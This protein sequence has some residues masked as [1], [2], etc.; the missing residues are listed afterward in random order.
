MKNA[1]SAYNA[2]CAMYG[3]HRKIIQ[4]AL[5]IAHCLTALLLLS[6][7][8]RNDLPYPRLQQNITAIAAEGELSPAVIDTANLTVTL[9]LSEQADIRKVRFTEFAYTPGAECDDD[10][11][12]GTYDM[13]LPIQVTLSRYQSYQW[14]IQA[15]QTIERYF[16]LSG[17]IGQS[18]IDVPG[19]RVVVYMPESVPLNRVQL[20]S[21]KLGPESITTIS[22]EL[23]EGQYLDLSNPMTVKVS[24]YGRTETWTIFAIHTDAIVTTTQV[25]AWSMVIYAYGSAPEDAHNGFQYRLATARDWTNVPEAWVTRNGGAFSCRIPGLL[26]MTEYV[27]RATSDDNLGNEVTVTTQSTLD[28]PDGSFDQWWLKNNKIW[29]PWSE[30]GTQFWDTGNTGAATL[31]NSNV[32]PSDDTPSGTGKSACLETR[33][34]GIGIVGKLAAGSIY[35][36]TFVKVDGTNGILD[37]G[38]PWSVR[39]TRLRGFYKFHTEPINYAS[40]EFKHLMGR[41]DSCHI[42]IA[43]TDWEV[44]YQIRTNPS[45]RQ[46]FDRNSPAVIAYGDLVRGSDTNGWQEFEITLRYRSTSRVPKYILVTCAASKYG[47]YFTGG[48]GTVLYVDQLS[49]DYDY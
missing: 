18:V 5:Y 33:F 24:A 25:D 13:S 27:V 8:I 14:I 29:C 9:R 16:T 36:G 1:N 12:Q 26:P 45:N 49:L 22:P 37:F 41:P 2:Q 46:L 34:V 21:C 42:Y 4:C 19:R 20:T 32:Y 17:Q 3:R 15:E 44:P 35:T 38:R 40:S 47:D 28:L 7:C 31:G 43:M 10:L 6:G 11:L 30:N 48:T 23:K 39:P